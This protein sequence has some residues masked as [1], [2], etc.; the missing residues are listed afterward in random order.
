MAVESLRVA[1][2]TR[3]SYSSPAT[4]LPSS[5][6]FR[7]FNLRFIVSASNDGSLAGMFFFFLGAFYGV[8]IGSWL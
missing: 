8:K 6:K 5:S 2:N 4:A 7:P 3:L 1:P